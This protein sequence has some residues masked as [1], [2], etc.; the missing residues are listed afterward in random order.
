MQYAAGGMEAQRS[1]LDVLA[2]NLALV[3]TAD[4]AHPVHPLVPQFSS[5]PTDDDFAASLASLGVTQTGDDGDFATGPDAE[6]SFAADLPDALDPLPG[7]VRFAGARPSPTAVSGID[8]VSEMVGV[9]DAQRAF[10]ADAS[11]FDTGKRLIEKTLDVERT[12]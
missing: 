10:E 2:A 12:T 7:Q 3:Q 1:A 4:A 9:L 6:P 11:V 5:T 8:A